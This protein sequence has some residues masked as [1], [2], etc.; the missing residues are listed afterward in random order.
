MADLGAMLRKMKVSKD[1]WS[2]DR[3]NIFALARSEGRAF[4]APPTTDFA[5]QC[6]VCGA[7]FGPRVYYSELNATDVGF[8]SAEHVQVYRDRQKIP[9]AP[10]SAPLLARR[11]P[12]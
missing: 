8:C 5:H 12:A 11:T 3:G 6:E 9:A 10:V 7:S 1:N 2:M 4:E